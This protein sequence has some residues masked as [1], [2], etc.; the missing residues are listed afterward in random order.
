LPRTLICPEINRRFSPFVLQSKATPPRHPGLARASSGYPPGPTGPKIVLE[1]ERPS[2]PKPTADQTIT[3][4]APETHPPAPAPQVKRKRPRPMPDVPPVF[5]Q[6]VD[7]YQKHPSPETYEAVTTAYLQVKLADQKL[8][9]EP[10]RLSQAISTEE[11][12]ASRWLKTWQEAQL[13]LE[14]QTA[15]ARKSADRADQWKAYLKELFDGL[16]PK[17]QKRFSPDGDLA[18][19]RPGIFTKGGFFL[20]RSGHKFAKAR[21]EANEDLKAGRDDK[22]KLDRLKEQAADAR[23]QHETRLKNVDQLKEALKSAERDAPL[24]AEKM[25]NTEIVYT[26]V[27]VHAYERFPELGPKKSHSHGHGHGGGMEI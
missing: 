14:Q 7:T 27:K 8:Q 24:S 10:R 22:I 2:P 4:V 17:E 19:H 1:R 12:Q 20:S 21:E 23:S 18:K 3:Q 6:A 5:A 26:R 13:P 16:T 11:N 15:K 25:N 9:A